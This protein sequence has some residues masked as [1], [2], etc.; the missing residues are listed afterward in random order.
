MSLGMV[1]EIKIIDD[2][3]FKVSYP[4]PYGGFARRLTIESWV[5]YTLI[6][7]PSHYLKQYHIKYTTLDKLS[8]DL[9]NTGK[10]TSSSSSVNRTLA[11]CQNRMAGCA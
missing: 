11:S 10:A 5:G 1:N 9:K 4:K 8:E 7:N 3:T 6:L 2:Y